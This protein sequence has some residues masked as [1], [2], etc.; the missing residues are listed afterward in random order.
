MDTFNNYIDEFVDWVTGEDTSSQEEEQKTRVSSTGGLPVA[1]KFIRELI[2]SRLKKPFV[3]YEDTVNGLYRLFSS[4]A[5]KNKWIRMN[6]VGSSDYDPEASEKLELFNFVRPSDVVM[7]YTGLTPNP[8]YII[9]G[10]TDSEAAWLRYNVYL[11]KEQ[12]GATIYESDSF[13]VTYKITD[14]NGVDHIESEGKDTSF[15]NAPTNPINKNIYDYL[16]VGQNNVVITMKANNSSAQNSV[17]FPVY[18]IEF[19]LSSTF[20][21]ANHWNP[22]LP[23]EVPISVKRSN[24]NLTLEVNVYGIH[25]NEN[26]SPSGTPIASWTINNTE[27]NPT[28]TFNIENVFSQNITSQD[29]IKHMLK[30]E[31]KMYDQNSASVYYSNILFFDF[32]VASETIGI[33][34]RFVNISYSTP[35]TR[36]ITEDNG[37]VIL[38]ATQFNSFSLPWAYYTDRENTEQNP[39]IKWMIKK[40]NGNETTYDL[41][42][43]LQGQNKQSGELLKFIPDFYTENGDEVYLV[44]MIGNTEVDQFPFQ[45]AKSK[46][47]I[48][49][50]GN[51]DLKLSAFGKSNL[52]VDRN[53][54][55]DISHNISTTFY[56]I[57]Y[58]GNSGWDDNSFVTS[59]TS[60]YAIINFC[61]I[62][63]QYNLAGQ[64]RTIEIDFK[65]E[66]VVNEDDVLAIIGNPEGGHIKITTNEAGLYNGVNHIV[67]TN[68]K[69]NERIKLAFIFNPVQMGSSDSNLIFIVNN[70]VLERAKDYGAASS[71]TSDLGIFKIGGS[72]SGIRIYNIR[73]YPRAISADDELKN[74]I[75]D[76]DNKAV[77]L[78]RNDIYNN[79]VIDY[80]LV[81]NKIDT[82]LITGDL[83]NILRQSSGKTESTSTVDI[84]RNCITDPSK[85]F[86]VTN[87]MIR[88]HG[89]STLNYPITSLKIWTNKAKETNVSTVI[90]LS[91]QQRAEGLNKNRYISKTGSIPANKFVLQANYADSSGVH[92][93]GLLR[94]IQDTWYN[95]NFGTRE[96]PIYRLRTAPQLFASGYTV[97]H[98]D[99]DLHEIGWVDGLGAGAKGT[100]KTW[101]QISD[102]PF[103]YVIRNAPDS[104][105][106]SVFYQNGPN[107]QLH[108]LGQYVFMDDKKSDYTYGERSIYYFGTGNDPFV[109]KTEN[110]KN[111]PLGKQDTKENLV[112][113]NK[114]VLRIEVVV[115]NA[116]L[117]SYMDFNVTDEL[118]VSHTCTDIKYSPTGDP[119]HYY[120]E[121]YFEMIYPD[122]DDVAEDDAKDGKTKFS[123]DSK[124]ITKVTPF[125][126]LLKW[127]TDCKNNY[128]KNTQWWSAGTYNSTQQAFEATAHE[129][130]DMYKLAAYYIFFLRFGLV[131]SVE[132]NA[133]LKTYDGQHWHYEPWDMDIALGNTNQGALVLN[134]PMTRND[135]EPGTTTYAFSGRTLTS[136]NV[137]WDCLEAWDYWSNRLVPEVAQALYDAGLNYDNIIKMFDGEYSDKWSETMYNY[138]GHFKY[139]D[140]GGSDWL[141]WLQGS[142]ASHRHW[143]I[144]TSMNYYD[145]KWSCGSFNEH[146]IRIFADKETNPTGTDVITIYP[147]SSTFFKVAQQEGRTSLGTQPASR[148]EPA[149]FDV[150]TAAFSAKDPSYIY[151]GT[152]VER[153]NLSCLAEKLK[154][155]DFSLCY[156]QVLGAPIKEINVGLP[157]QVI[158]E[159]EYRGKVSGTQ[160]RLTGYNT[161][162]D[163]DAF[164][165]LQVLDIT[166]QSTIDNTQELLGARNRRN[167]VDFF[168]IGSG[169]TSFTSSTSGNKFNTIKLPG[170]TTITYSQGNPT[171]SEF[172]TLTMTNSS[173]NTIEFWNTTKNG[174]ITYVR[175][176]NGEIV[177]DDDNNPVIAANLATFTRSSVPYQ[178]RTI[179]FK[180]STASNECSGRFLLDWINSIEANLRT[181]N[182]S[183]T[184]EQLEEA[185]L[186]TL[187]TKQFE[188]ENINWGVPGQSLRLTYKDLTRIAC[189]NNGNNSGGLLKGYIMISD[190]EELTTLQVNKLMQWFGPSVF[191]KNAKSSNLV[192]DQQ[193]GSGY[194]RIVTSNTTIDSETGDICL[195]EGQTTA[196]NATKFILS[197]DD[198]TQYNWS[199]AVGQ[200]ITSYGVPS[201]NSVRLHIEDDGI[202]YLTANQ[203]GTY[204]DYYI[205]VTAE[206]AG[207]SHTVTIK[208]IGVVLPVDISIQTH[209][210]GGVDTRKFYLSRNLDT[211]MPEFVNN[212]LDE[213]YR[214]PITNQPNVR[215]S[216][217]LFRVG[218][219]IEFYPEKV[220]GNIPSSVELKGFTYQIPGLLSTYTNARDLSGM[221]DTLDNRVGDGF[222]YYTKSAT[223]N[224]IVLGVQAFP[225]TMTIYNLKLNCYAGER[226]FNRTIN[227]I[228]M[229]DDVVM[230][231]SST[232]V[233]VQ[234]TLNALHTELFGNSILNYYKSDLISLVGTLNFNTY[235]A[236][237]G[238]V[239]ATD[240]NSLLK[241][242]PN[243]T[244][245]DFSECS[246]LGAESLGMYNN[247]VLTF[248]GM[249][250]L[251]HISFNDSS[252]SYVVDFSNCPYL[253]NIDLRNTR[254]GIILSNGNRVSSLQL[255]SPGTVSI[256]GPQILGDVGTT[257]TI[258]SSQYL[259]N[260][261]LVNCN[262]TNLH[263]FAIFNT[264]V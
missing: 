169:L 25:G 50:I 18:L 162:E 204:G 143:W 198:S 135:F 56:G 6:T 257:V 43:T 126:N 51:Y 216:F 208:I 183:Y 85:N 190:P 235:K 194:I 74:Y 245:L 17:S 82:V 62:P 32:V 184:T 259:D 227:I 61:P 262:T 240:N 99:E 117:S 200:N 38:Q 105:P 24:T 246:N 132:R 193:L 178:L 122:E 210:V 165:N 112:W 101:A 261:E 34:N 130:L 258:Q 65:T 213:N 140:N 217:V 197:E 173:W 224:G 5:T 78:N 139:I 129:H 152:F 40:V 36:L 179:Q 234:N 188:A 142:R 81:K 147:T 86:S 30:I 97:T 15:L 45:V 106:C 163:T 125:I 153:I 128:N 58:D 55:E 16:T 218:Q 263:G 231:S 253:T 248:E 161:T 133:Q 192:I 202:M 121:D 189:L 171:Y 244:Q 69:A 264:L 233:G 118:G 20:N 22:N 54:W 168:A 8:R 115:P 60:S 255:G 89:Q 156:D 48:V 44:A 252:L 75:Y 28:H 219:K 108:F 239:R 64:G 175:D 134:P 251:T 2:Q 52:S 68:Y 211:F 63:A 111:G 223:H 137:L 116:P 31:A 127:I 166:G 26:T 76:S 87:G 19:E 167:I 229:N 119:D 247:G 4:E 195:R 113:D 94:L 14:S 33:T 100:G 174:D 66:K 53:R 254:A 226:I 212:V 84:E 260:I 215:N 80:G 120:W 11:S 83:S 222:L 225:S 29:H 123:Q 164:E 93:G 154:A 79:G 104:F 221:E 35:F 160:F 27:T 172:G 46:L 237:V 90:N 88:K 187:K 157:Y 42:T 220:D 256:T 37:R 249:N 214:D 148:A 72:Q 228:L 138:S 177:Y 92:N 196:L 206:Y 186:E 1:G 9:N 185:L 47:S 243:I 98:D 7:S 102:R 201:V 109:L 241:Y 207:I 155:A 91:E 149:R 230:H 238:T 158:S 114:N 23:L 232:S 181:L 124:F 57:Q 21:I 151:G 182:P 199:V 10:D 96:N 13:T 136:S 49:E 191:T 12:Q 95:A 150:S 209:T 77:I 70:G 242:L 180:G 205:T 141:A 3:Y 59:G 71:Y 67:H 103:P 176:D 203:D 131:D 159:N 146:R 39:D 145:A 170:T 236:Q 110:T 73:C 107:D 250:K 144:S 41:I